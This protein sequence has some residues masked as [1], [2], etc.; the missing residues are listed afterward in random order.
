MKF[1]TSRS[2]LLLAGALAGGGAFTGLAHAAEGRPDLIVIQPA[3]VPD[4]SNASRAP[5]P[6]QRRF[7]DIK[8]PDARAVDKELPPNT[9]ATEPAMPPAPTVA[10]FQ[11][12]PIGDP[13]LSMTGRPSVGV[14]AGLAAPTMTASIRNQAAGDRQQM[15]KDVETRIE[16][17][18]STLKTWRGTQ[19]EL[20]AD[21]RDQFKAVGEEVE[22]K[23]KAV[24]KSLAAARRANDQNW[25]TARAQLA[26]DYEAYAAAAGRFDA[27]LGVP[28]VQN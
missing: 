24:R 13:A 16:A 4:G 19:R 28:P 5:F 23:A 3:T 27:V 26:A 20:S 14:A 25:E 22:T 2:A 21:S 18:E 8:G 10:I 6:A 11:R 7:D 9:P 17:S 12:G 15:L 1:V